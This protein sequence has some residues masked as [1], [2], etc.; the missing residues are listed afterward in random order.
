MSDTPASSPNLSRRAVLGWGSALAASAAAAVIAGPP[1]AH[2]SE[3]AGDDRTKHHA[4]ATLPYDEMQAVLQAEGSVTDAGVL[5]VGLER[6]DVDGATIGGI[7]AVPSFELESSLTFQPLRHGWGF[8]NGDFGLRQDEV[9][10]VIDAI[11]ANGLVFQAFHQHYDEMDP[12][13]WFIHTRGVGEGVDLATRVHNVLLATSIPLPQSPPPDPTTPLDEDGLREI[14]GGYRSEVGSD[15]VVTVYVARREIIT[16]DGIRTLPDTNIATNVMFE[17]LDDSG[18][19]A[20]V[21]PDFSLVASE[22]NDVTRVMRGAGWDSG[23]LYNQET[24][25]HPQLY[26]QHMIKAGDPTELANEV[27]AGLNLMRMRFAS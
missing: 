3:A 25:E 11:L 10:G 27:R 6:D 19:Q 23:C 14:L 26:F 18:S 15:G 22:I 12:L 5:T 13:L 20:A 7:P 9:N 2:A 21:A 17:P 8:F 16:I 24:A 4:R 1:S